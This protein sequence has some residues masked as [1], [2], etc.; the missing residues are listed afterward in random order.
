M[1]E[2]DLVLDT[3]ILIEILRGTPEA[4]KWLNAHRD[5][6]I[7]IPVIVRMEILQG[8][9]NKREQQVLIRELRKFHVLHLESGDTE[10]AL[11]W[12][13]SFYLSHNL[14]IMDCL[15]ASIAVRLDKP[16]Y[17]FNIKHYRPIKELDVQLPYRRSSR[18]Q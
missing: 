3:D 4:A 13:E 17:T 10:R 12:F 9:R 18:E 16:L 11:S 1:V 2:P 8:A 7:G 14:G 6:T 5:R 15:I